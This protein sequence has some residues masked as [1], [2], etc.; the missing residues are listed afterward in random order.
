MRSEVWDQC[1]D[2]Q[3]WIATMT[4][5]PVVDFDTFKPAARAL[6]CQDYRDYKA[7]II[8]AKIAWIRPEAQKGE[9]KACAELP[10][11]SKIVDR[12]MSNTM[13]SISQ[14][15]YSRWLDDELEIITLN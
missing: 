1:T 13:Y 10:E 8:M 3:G 9:P 2:E 14:I 6:Y 4:K 11:I 15:N 12:M 5:E 7:S